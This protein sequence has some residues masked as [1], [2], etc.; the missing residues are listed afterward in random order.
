[1]PPRIRWIR[2]LPSE[3]I[4]READVA[5]GTGIVACVDEDRRRRFGKVGYGTYSSSPVK[6]KFRSAY[7][8]YYE[9]TAKI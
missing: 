8:S 7:V 9:D 1:M 6:H 3:E 2:P 4:A 5:A